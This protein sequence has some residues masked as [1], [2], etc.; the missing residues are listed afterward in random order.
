M[1]LEVPANIVV[2][3]LAGKTTLAKE[4]DLAEDVMLRR[5]F[6]EGWQVTGCSLKEGAI[7][8]GLAPKVVFEMAPPPEPVFWSKR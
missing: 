5:V 7:E 6:E 2:D 8:K 1:R 3:A 4:C